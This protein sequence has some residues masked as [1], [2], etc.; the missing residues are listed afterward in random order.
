[1]IQQVNPWLDEMEIQSVTDTIDN[2][3]ITEGPK[4]AEAIE[5]LKDLL[6]LSCVTFAP[7]GTLGLLLGFLL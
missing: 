7:N 5:K 2:N 6:G 3:W 1:M 4:C